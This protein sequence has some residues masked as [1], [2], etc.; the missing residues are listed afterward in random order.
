ME[1][2]IP[3]LDEELIPLLDSFRPGNDP[4]PAQ[5]SIEEMVDK[6]WAEYIPCLGY[7][8]L[9]RHCATES[10]SRD[11]VDSI[12]NKCAGE[13]HKDKKIDAIAENN[14]VKR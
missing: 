4:V 14:K 11:S 5:P 10:Q 9:G 3:L 1:S 6:P 8:K 13:E 2:F 12:V 7:T